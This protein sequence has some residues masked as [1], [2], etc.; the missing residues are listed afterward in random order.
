MTAF[1]PPI[2]LKRQYA[3]MQDEVDAAIARVM[4]SG[5][6]ISGPETKA[7]EQEYAAYCGV[8]HAVA[9]G[10]GSASLNLTLKAL[11]IGVG[12]DVIT[13]AFTHSATLDAIVDLGATQVL[14]DVT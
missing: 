4:A 5:W 6:F 7:F 2:D 9:L 14:V 10:S 11:G 1:I 8:D 3:S 13:V 12:D